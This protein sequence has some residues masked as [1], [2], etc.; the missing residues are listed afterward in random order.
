MEPITSVVAPAYVDEMVH[1]I[2]GANMARYFPEL[3]SAT[4]VPQ[5]W[6]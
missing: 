4:D 6:P 3:G 2:C 5:L 1:S